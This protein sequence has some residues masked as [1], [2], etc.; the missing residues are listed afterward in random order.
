MRQLYSLGQGS[1]ARRV[2]KSCQ[3]SGAID[4][5]GGS[6]AAFSEPLFEAVVGVEKN[7]VLHPNLLGGVG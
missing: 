2:G 7:D 5:D 6:R 4:V 1:G 3:V